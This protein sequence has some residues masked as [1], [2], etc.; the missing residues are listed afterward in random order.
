M[1]HEELRGP[2]APPTREGFE[3]A[4]RRELARLNVRLSSTTGRT[5]HT[6]ED[7]KLLEGDS[8]DVRWADMDTVRRWS[9]NPVGHVGGA[10]PARRPAPPR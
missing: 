7:S 4:R 2:E 9:S 1:E 6:P 5:C 10:K 3:Q 8:A